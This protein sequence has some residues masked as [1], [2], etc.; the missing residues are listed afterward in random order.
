MGEGFHPE[1]L[2]NKDDK[3][4]GVF[5]RVT[6]VKTLKPANTNVLLWLHPSVR[7]T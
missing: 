2:G 5:K 4:I 1:I 3:G 7:G 6:V